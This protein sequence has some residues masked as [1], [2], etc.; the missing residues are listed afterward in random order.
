M[1]KSNY[2]YVK[3]WRKRNR[4]K[5]NAQAA[6]RRKRCPEKFA[7]IKKRSRSKGGQALKD[8][9]AKQ[10]R[11]RRRGNPEANRIRLARFKAKREAQR[12]EEAG[13]PRPSV[14]DICSGNHHLGI[15]FDHC[16][17]SGKFRGWLC[18]RCNKVLGLIG[19]DPKL[20]RRMARYLDRHNG[21]TDQQGTQ[22]TP[23]ERLCWAGSVVSSK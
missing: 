16:H 18:D 17:Q 4:D 8:K 3:D 11:E 6:R 20:L 19:D 13:R 10:A 22:L 12:V 2:E 21:E 7:E 14:C 23:I 1:A 15:V 9:E 5:V